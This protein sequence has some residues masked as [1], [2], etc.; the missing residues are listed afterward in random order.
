M[1]TNH[2]VDL[3]PSSQERLDAENFIK[4]TLLFDYILPDSNA[5]SKNIVDETLNMT[6]Q[7]C[8]KLFSKDPNKIEYTFFGDGAFDH[9]TS[10]S[11]T[12]NTLIYLNHF[13]IL[14]PVS[15]EI[16]KYPSLHYMIL[17]NCV[18]SSY[19]A[20]LTEYL[21]SL[22]IT[23]YMLNSLN[24]SGAY[25]AIQKNRLISKENKLIYRKIQDQSK[26][27][28]EKSSKASDFNKNFNNR[29]I[30]ASDLMSF[31]RPTNTS[32]NRYLLQFATLCKSINNI[33]SPLLKKVCDNKKIDEKIYSTI[34]KLI[35]TLTPP[36]G[37]FSPVGNR[38]F[39]DF[40]GSVID[41]VYHYYIAEKAYNF[42]LFYSILQNIKRTEENYNYQ[43]RSEEILKVISSCKKLPNS[44]SRTYFLHFAFDHIFSQ[45]NSYRDYWHYH[46]IDRRDIGMSNTRKMKTGFQ[47]DKWCEQFSRFTEYMSDHIIPIY[48]WC[49]LTM[50]LH[51]I[52][53]SFPDKNHTFH[54]DKAIHILG[55]YIKQN[56]QQIMQ[57]IKLKK[58]DDV[59]IISQKNITMLQAYFS[60]KLKPIFSIFFSTY[61]TELNIKTIIPQLYRG[62]GPY[63]EQYPF[64]LIADFYYDLRFNYRNNK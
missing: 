52:E 11:K 44:F 48:D 40:N 20:I 43:F 10:K 5:D 33:P 56:Y 29:L 60:D 18:M 41:G 54:L 55:T 7:C 45:G 31:L 61:E 30:Y 14:K 59:D 9:N 57:P 38:N 24:G 62:N 34:E 46:D 15:E 25:T 17:Q 37:K 32:Q 53:R 3:H 27:N 1:I 22:E 64:N 51:V 47:F 50:L 35:I 19:H 12:P 39:K 28:K 23:S 13:P 42:N 16:S 58:M 36:I 26:D 21:L 2:L 8:H 63:L 6:H 49:F 4:Y